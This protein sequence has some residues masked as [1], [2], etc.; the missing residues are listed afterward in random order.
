M[1]WWQSLHANRKV[2]FWWDPKCKTFQYDTT[3]KLCG[4]F[5]LTM[6]N[7]EATS[8][9]RLAM[10]ST[11]PRVW[12]H[13]WIRV[14]TSVLVLTVAMSPYLSKPFAVWHILCSIQALTS[15]ASLIRH[16]LAALPENKWC[17]G[18]NY[19]VA[20]PQRMTFLQQDSDT[21]N[22]SAGFTELLSHQGR[23]S[24]CN[25]VAKVSRRNIIVVS[26]Y[27]KTPFC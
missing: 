11:G 2:T 9:Q 13:L 14:Q 10:G 3:A 18:K 22:K 26:G 24:C 25:L 8:D 17:R 21:E 20:C 19:K 1:K 12:W 7:A 15:R 6:W 4:W 16:S 5:V 23:L 27:R